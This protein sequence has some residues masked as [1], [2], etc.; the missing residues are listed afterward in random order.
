MQGVI[1]AGGKGTR[2]SPFTK[3]IN[4][5]LLPV[6]P[7][8]MI[9]WPISRLKQAGITDILIITN[10]QDL[11]SFQQILGNGEDLNVQL[12]YT[13]QQENGG[14]IADALYS[15]KDFVTDKFVMV[16]GDNLFEEDLSNF[17]Q[18]FEAGSHEAIVFLKEVPDPERYGVA[19][20]DEQTESIMT[21]VEKPKVAASNFC[22]TGIYFYDQRVFQYIESLTP[23]SR[24]EMEITDLNNLY[25]NRKALHYK[26]LSKWWLDAGTHDSLYRANQFYYENGLRGDLV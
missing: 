5:H 1:L 19:I 17:V 13:I 25:I 20:L 12:S 2:L 15:A 10:Q 7:F 16:L 21:I 14:G 22:V 18:E 24:G 4:K 11:V 23:S 26:K 3:V 8:P 6:G 9:Y